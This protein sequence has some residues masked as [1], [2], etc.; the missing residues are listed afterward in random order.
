MSEPVQSPKPSSINPTLPPAAQPQ[1]AAEKLIEVNLAADK[2]LP[3]DITV[4]ENEKA[5]VGRIIRFTVSPGDEAKIGHD[6][7]DRT[8]WIFKEH[9]KSTTGVGIS[10]DTMLSF[11]KNEDGSV[12]YTMKVGVNERGKINLSIGDNAY[13]LK[14][15]EI[16]KG[17]I[18]KHVPNHGSIP[19]ITIKD[20]KGNDVR[21]MEALNKDGYT[22]IDFYGM[23]CPPCQKLMT[24]PNGISSLINEIKDDQFTSPDGK[25]FN[26]KGIKLMLI[27][28]FGEEATD[29]DAY[30]KEK[31]DTGKLPKDGDKFLSLMDHEKG[32]QQFK[33]SGIPSL[34]LVAPDGKIVAAWFQ[35]NKDGDIGSYSDIRGYLESHK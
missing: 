24:A 21:L 12:T 10:K 32:V 18:P 31:Q 6:G 33:F 35:G 25:P 9:D 27:N 30:I 11:K 16:S 20:T 1:K 19:D 28:T 7:S 23:A 4:P 26:S 3:K 8:S 2:N 34:A 14:G 15:S 17:E 5:K 22:L 13:E 29:I